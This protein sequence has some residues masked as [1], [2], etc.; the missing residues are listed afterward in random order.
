MDFSK[1]VVNHFEVNKTRGEC[2]KEGFSGVRRDELIGA[3]EIWMMGS[4][5]RT[6]SDVEIALN[7]RALNQ[8]YEEV[9]QL[10]P[11]SVDHG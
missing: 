9:F 10:T 3:Y 4:V 7:S 11:G 2:K 8:A 6:V 1:P 5:A